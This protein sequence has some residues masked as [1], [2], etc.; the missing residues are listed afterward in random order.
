[1][2][3]VLRDTKN[4]TTSGELLKAAAISGVLPSLSLNMF[5]SK[6]VWPSNTL[7]WPAS[8]LLMAMNIAVEGLTGA[9]WVGG[10]VRVLI[11]EVSAG[12]YGG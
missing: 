10:G 1:M 2:S 4:L 7:K 9:P 3:K 5:K 11:E 6:F 12:E 8:L